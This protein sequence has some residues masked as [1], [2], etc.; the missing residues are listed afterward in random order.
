MPVHVSSIF[1]FVLRLLEKEN[2]N[3]VKISKTFSAT[4]QNKYIPIYSNL[5]TQK[6][7]ERKIKN[8]P[9]TPKKG[10]PDFLSL[11]NPEVPNFSL[12]KVSESL[13]KQERQIENAKAR[14]FARIEAT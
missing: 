13:T 8:T 5:R 12:L 3:H 4:D 2:S 9:L 7:R 11:Q 6:N 10:N 1:L 14:A